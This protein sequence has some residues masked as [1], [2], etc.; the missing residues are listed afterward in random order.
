MLLNE[1]K[2]IGHPGALE[3][4]WS[5]VRIFLNAACK[6]VDII[7]IIV[8]DCPWRIMGSEGTFSLLRAQNVKERKFQS[9][10]CKLNTTFAGIPRYN[11][12]TVHEDSCT[13]Y[14]T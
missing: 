2:G 12:H 4:I 10:E 5:C 8:F 13:E 9:I 11:K 3:V 6:V 7:L 14:Y 1:K